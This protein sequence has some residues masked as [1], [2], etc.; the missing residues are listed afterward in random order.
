MIQ[1]RLSWILLLV[2]S[3]TILT[4]GFSGKIEAQ[5]T[6][7]NV[8]VYPTTLKAG[9]NT[10]VVITIINSF[11]PIY[12]MDITVSFPQSQVTSIS[13][14]IIGTSNM[15][16]EKLNQG[17]NVT[18]NQLVFVPEEAAGSGYQAN[19]MITYKRL[20]YISPYSELHTVGFYV[21]GKIIMVMY[22]L[23]VEPEAITTGSTLTLTGNILNKGNIPA[24]Y[25]NASLLPHSILLMKPES[26]SYL[27]EIEPD[28]PLPFTLEA[29]VSPIAEQGRYEIMMHLDYEDKEGQVYR[30]EETIPFNIVVLEEK[31]T[32]TSIE[33]I[34]RIIEDE[35]IY[36]IIIII[37]LIVILALAVKVRRSSR[38]EFQ[39][40]ELPT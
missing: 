30:M 18:L 9:F 38:S 31:Q 5:I 16:F 23:F 39:D 2:L 17:D 19:I 3:L 25:T 27:G 36:F 24:L 14:V 20:G 26:Y 37:M 33:R 35:L 1:K 6:N 8:S 11:E 28:S 4:S 13:P 15:K 22:D 40:E 32:E 29:T 10:S 12:D 7:L 21:K 34:M